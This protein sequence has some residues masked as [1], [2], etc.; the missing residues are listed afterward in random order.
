RILGKSQTPTESPAHKA[1][2]GSEGDTSGDGIL[3]REIYL[4]G[5]AYLGTAWTY[6]SSDLTRVGL[7]TI[8]NLVDASTLFTPSFFWD[9]NEQTSLSVGALLGV[10]RRLD[11]NGVA[12]EF[13]LYPYTVF[14]DARVYF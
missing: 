9:A 4:L 7:S 10:G 14:A 1:S 2:Q 8:T 12:D 11:A 13:G 3:V 6:R 5:S